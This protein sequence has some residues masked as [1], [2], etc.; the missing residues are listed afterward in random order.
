[1]RKARVVIFGLLLAALSTAYAEDKKVEVNIWNNPEANMPLSA[2]LSLSFRDELWEEVYPDTYFDIQR[3]EML[4][5]FSLT[6]YES[7]MDNLQDDFQDDVE[8]AVRHTLEDYV[9]QSDWFIDSVDRLRDWGIKVRADFRRD[10]DPYG[11][12][13]LEI[14]TGVEL[15]SED[16]NSRNRFLDAGV[17]WRKIDNPAAYIKFG[18][19]GDNE[20]LHHLRYEPFREHIELETYANGWGTRFRYHFDDEALDFTILDAPFDVPEDVGVRFGALYDFDD[21]EYGAKFEVF[22]TFRSLNLNKLLFW[23][24]K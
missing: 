12:R 18:H 20:W 15:I 21:D 11:E 6:G 22:G 3:A 13:E 4:R 23:R 16:S 7:E 17:S 19:N 10:E 24:K 2:K 14:D 1:M 8:D 9:R 5:T